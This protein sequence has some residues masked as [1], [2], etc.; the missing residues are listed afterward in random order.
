M[1]HSASAT[2]DYSTIINNNDN[3][4]NNNLGVFLTKSYKVLKQATNE[5]HLPVNLS[6]NVAM[7]LLALNAQT[8]FFFFCTRL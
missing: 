6:I 5:G 7:P 2:S 8:V 1:R 3:I 4:N